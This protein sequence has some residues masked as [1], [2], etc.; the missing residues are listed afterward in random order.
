MHETKDCFQDVV[1]EHFALLIHPDLLM[2]LLSP[3][4]AKITERDAN[5][6]I[7]STSVIKYVDV[8]YNMHCLFAIKQC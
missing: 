5:S 7:I 6:N 4:A 2:L 8:H 3:L 1:K